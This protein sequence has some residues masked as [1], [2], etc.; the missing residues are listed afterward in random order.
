MSSA[1]VK[2]PD[3]SKA[4]WELNEVG[5]SIIPLGS[6]YERPPQWFLNDRCGGDEKKAAA[7]WPKTPRIGWKQYQ[8]Q[9]PTDTNIEHWVTLWPCCNWAIITGHKV[10]VVDADSAAAVEFIESGPVT[11]TPLRALTSKGKHYY[12]RVNPDNP[13]RNCAQKNKIDIRGAGGYVVAPGSTHADGTRYQW[14]TDESYA[15]DDL[16]DLPSLTTDDIA[17]INSFDEGTE[18]NT[19]QYVGNLGFSVS[20]YPV[21]HVG[22]SLAEGEGRNNAAASIVGQYIRQGVSLQQIKSLLDQ[23]NATNTPPLSCNELNTTIASV[24]RTHLNNHPESTIAI[25]P[26]MAQAPPFQFSHV[27]DLLNSAGAINWLIKGFLEMDSLCVLFG[28]PA[29]GKSFIAIDL[30]C[31]I[32]T[33]NSWHGKSVKKMGAVFYI[34]GEGFN[35]LSRRIMAWQQEHGYSF[36]KVPLYISQYSAALTDM[37]N[38]HAVSQSI[39]ETIHQ[40]G[41]E[42]PSL[43]VIDTLA[44]NFGP[45][46]ENGTKEMNLF[47]NHID[48]YFRQKYGCCVLVVHHTGVGNKDRARGNSAL[49]GAADAEYAV[50]KN[51]EG[52]KIST[53]KMKDAEALPPIEFQLKPVTLPFCDEDGDPQA[54]CVLQYLDPSNAQSIRVVKG[55]ES[56]I[57][58][59]QRHIIQTLDKLLKEARSNLVGQERDPKLARIEVKHLRSQCLDDKIVGKNNWSRTFDSIVERKFLEIQS[60]FVMLT[61]KG[62]EVI[63]DA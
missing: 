49:K 58:S 19:N 7:D 28:E 16:F 37:V 63:S 55:M 12:Y 15:L 33:G 41:G 53:K 13:V 56:H 3:T 51:D 57:G 48:H 25:E 26:V 5:L 34:A 43:I 4:A 60:P 59:T 22:S 14:E 18:A 2:P 35:G 61:D 6:P 50:V 11:R 45:A 31:C 47:I 21:P 40:T 62:S 8:D 17:A 52:I 29:C 32:A 9:A 27:T 44:R 36:A 42:A 54:S 30:A 24:A 39:E 20:Q 10:V 46:D 38:A 23:W 1:S